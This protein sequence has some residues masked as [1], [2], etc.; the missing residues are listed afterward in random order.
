MHVLAVAQPAVALDALERLFG[1]RVVLPA[2]AIILRERR[3]TAVLQLQRRL[4]KRV[5][6]AELHLAFRN[7][8][9]SLVNQVRHNHKNACAR[10]AET[11]ILGRRALER[12]PHPKIVARHVK[13]HAAFLHEYVHAGPAIDTSI[14]KAKVHLLVALRP[15]H[16]AVDVYSAFRAALAIAPERVRDQ[17]TA[18]I[19]VYDAIRRGIG[20]LKLANFQFAA[21]GNRKLC[22]R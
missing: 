20:E 22:R 2:A 12:Q 17:P 18:V 9:R 19:E 13:R 5:M 8:R 6:V 16:A 11:G 10:L 1:V 7:R 21:V 15:D 4:R 3:N 14:P